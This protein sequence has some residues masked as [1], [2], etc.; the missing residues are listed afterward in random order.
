MANLLGIWLRTSGFLLRPAVHYEGKYW[1][2][3]Q[4]VDT[5]LRNKRNSM[6]TLLL[7]AVLTASLI[8]IGCV[9]IK[10]TTGINTCLL[11]KA[12]AEVLAYRIKQ[13][14]PAPKPD[15]QPPTTNPYSQAENLYS[16]AVGDVKGFL[17]G[18]VSDIRLKHEVSVSTSAFNETDAAKSLKTFREKGAELLGSGVTPTTDPVSPAALVEAAAKLVEEVK[19]LND[20]WVDAAVKSAQETVE[21]GYMEPFDKVDRDTLVRRYSQSAH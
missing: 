12:K 6:R 1:R 21:R 20:Q 3:R 14:F 2:P 11:Q 7:T 18:V 5:L 19:R 10:D 9:K 8:S 13:R 4:N 16:D 17:D 15:A